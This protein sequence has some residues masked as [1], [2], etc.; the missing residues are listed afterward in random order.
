VV[1]GC[2]DRCPSGVRVVVMVVVLLLL[3]GYWE[4]W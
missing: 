3:W 1:P 4:Y 2:V